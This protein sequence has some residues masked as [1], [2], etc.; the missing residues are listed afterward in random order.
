[1]LPRRQSSG[2]IIIRMNHLLPNVKGL[3]LVP[4]SQLPL[5]RCLDPRHECY[6]SS[7]TDAVQATV[8]RSWLVKHP[9]FFESVFGGSYTEKRVRVDEHSF[10]FVLGT[11]AEDFTELLADVDKA[12]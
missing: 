1:M 7:R 11:T 3:T 6:H 12:K 4:R 9:K 8:R 5:T 10:H 2:T